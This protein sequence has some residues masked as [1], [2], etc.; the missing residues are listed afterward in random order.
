MGTWYA[1]LTVETFLSKYFS[2]I[3]FILMPFIGFLLG[4]GHGIQIVIDVDGLS[5]RVPDTA[6]K[7]DSSVMSHATVPY[8]SELS[9]KEIEEGVVCQ[10]EVMMWQT[11]QS[12]EY[13]VSF[14]H[15]ASFVAVPDGSQNLI[16][17]LGLQETLST[18]HLNVY[19]SVADFPDVSSFSGEWVVVDGFNG[20][21]YYYREGAG[22]S[23]VLV[24]EKNDTVFSFS[25]DVIGSDASETEIQDEFQKIITTIEF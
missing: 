2:I 12:D 5:L 25:Y 17:H 8:C 20:Y 3:L 6:E 18:T 4:I 21:L 16:T 10:T 7:V 1:P 13:E 15:T 22:Y 9:E 23:G 14:Q 19:A 24:V 11:F